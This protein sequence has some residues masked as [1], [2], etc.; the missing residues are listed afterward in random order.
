MLNRPPVPSSLLHLAHSLGPLETGD[1]DT[2]SL[3]KAAV[4]ALFPSAPRGIEETENNNHYVLTYRGSSLQGLRIV[5]SVEVKQP[6]EGAPWLAL[7][8]SATLVGAKDVTLR[9]MGF[10]NNEFGRAGKPGERTE[11]PRESRL[12]PFVYDPILKVRKRA[13]AWSFVLTEADIARVA[14]ALAQ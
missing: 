5:A 14:K 6:H 9:M 1:V 4:R 11:G 7:D 8:V 2:G 3:P 13:R 12:R 10:V